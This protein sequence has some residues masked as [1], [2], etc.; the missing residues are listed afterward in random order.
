MAGRHGDAHAEPRLAVDEV[1][2][3]RHLDVGPGDGGEIPEPHQGPVLGGDHQLAN[4]LH[5]LEG[6]GGADTDIVVIDAHVARVHHHVLR[7]EY[8]NNGVEA[9][10]QLSNA[11]T[12]NIDV[13]H[14]LLGAID[15]HLADA[16]DQHQLFLQRVGGVEQVAP[17]VAL[18]GNRK[19]DAINITEVVQHDGVQGAGWQVGPGVLHPSAQLVENG[20]EVR[21]LIFRFEVDQYVGQAWASHR[22]LDPAHLGQALDSVFHDVGDLIL[23]FLG[24]GAGVGHQDLG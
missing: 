14:F 19:V 24:S 8:A 11:R 20:G 12:G 1:E 21:G 18:S 23:Y 6:A 9:D 13:D 10:A 16:V 2:L 4:L 15:Y 7:F 5:R 17:A 22:H 3:L